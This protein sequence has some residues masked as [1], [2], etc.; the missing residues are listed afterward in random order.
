MVQ[1]FKQRNLRPLFLKPSLARHSS[2]REE[3]SLRLFKSERA[4]HNPIVSFDI[5]I[6]CR[7]G[8]YHPLIHKPRPQSHNPVGLIDAVWPFN[9]RLAQSPF[10]LEDHV[11]SLIPFALYPAQFNALGY[12]RSFASL[13]NDRP[14]VRGPDSSNFI[15]LINLAEASRAPQLARVRTRE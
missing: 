1:L 4:Q 13:G 5:E 7:N 6:V 3:I 10:L 11:A 8:P 15:P 2:K 14:D 9:G 12:I